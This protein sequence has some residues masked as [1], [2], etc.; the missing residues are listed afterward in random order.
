MASFEQHRDKWRAQVMVNGVREKKSFTTKAEAQAWAK[1]REAE[2]KA[3]DGSQ[4]WRTV[5]ELFETYSDRVSSKKAGSKWEQSRITFFLT[6]NPELAAMTLRD[7]SSRDMGLW[8]DRRIAG[9]AAR[10]IK[11]V[12]NATVEREINLF[13][14]IFQTARKEWKWMSVSPLTDVKRPPQTLPRT[15]RVDMEAIERVLLALGHVEGDAPDSTSRRVAY[16]FLFAIETGMRAGE[17]RLL[18]WSR[19]HFEQRYVHLPKTKNGA[20]RDVP[21]T[22]RAEEI[23]RIME[24][25]KA[26]PVDSVFRLTANQIDI[27]FRNAKIRAGAP[28]LHFHDTRREALTRMSEVLSVMELSKVSGHKDINILQNVYY[29]PKVQTL[30]D[31]LRGT[32]KAGD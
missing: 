1:A 23:L 5:R 4:D 20:P 13:S 31:K 8:R 9:D 25:A 22:E 10:K 16:A 15:Q 17:I 30:A 32:R 3:A 28:E 19:V 18:E 2:L 24:Q 7:V 21:L 27:N 12:S 26:D 29:A 11:P 14:N 6:N